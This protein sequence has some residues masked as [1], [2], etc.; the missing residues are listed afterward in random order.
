MDE[1]RIKK[2]VIGRLPKCY[3]I[4]PLTWSGRSYFLVAA[5]KKDPCYLF[6]LE[7]N[8]ADTVWEGPGGV[9]SMVQVPG[10]DG[11]FLATRKFYSPQ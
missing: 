11:V 5:E 10:S 7:G 3:S 2:R 9:M 8:Q 4:A 1:I 6:D